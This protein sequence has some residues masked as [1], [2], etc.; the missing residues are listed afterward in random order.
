MRLHFALLGI[1]LLVLSV[2]GLI[3]QPLSERAPRLPGAAP[4]PSPEDEGAEPGYLGIIADDRQDMGRGVRVVEALP[5]SP[6]AAGGLTAG[7]VIGRIDGQEVQS[8]ADMAGVLQQAQVGQEVRFEVERGGELVELTVTLGQRPPPGERRFQDFGPIPHQ[9][10]SDD[11]NTLGPP[12]GGRRRLLGMSTV[13]LDP[14]IRGALAVPVEK[15]AVVTRVESRSPAAE[16]KIPIDAVIVSVDGNPVEGPADLAR[17]VAQ[18]G[19]GKTLEINYFVRGQRETA[20][21]TL[22][23]YS[24]GA[25]LGG[26]E[27][28]FGYPGSGGGGPATGPLMPAEQRVI[29]LEARIADLEA[30]LENIERMLKSA[31]P[32]K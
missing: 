3:A 15:G 31:V 29:Q 32:Q 16:A 14:T 21:V 11:P 30:R 18:A 6:A 1:L 22:R 12:G 2:P 17:F 7:D 19:A 25:G 28:P 5:Q 9:E 26:Q 8:L 27:M 23:D 13:A 4:R 10:S 24:G 20:R